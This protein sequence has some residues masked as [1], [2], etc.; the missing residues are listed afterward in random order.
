M[1]SLAVGRKTHLDFLVSCWTINRWLFL[2]C[3][4]ELR[5]VAVHTFSDTGLRSNQTAPAG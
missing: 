2:L 5:R 3:D 4:R 1:T